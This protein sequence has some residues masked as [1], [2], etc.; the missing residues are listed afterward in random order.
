MSLIED[1]EYSCL[2]NMGEVIIKPNDEAPMWWDLYV[3]G[4]LL[5]AAQFDSPER[6]ALSA[7]KRDFGHQDLNSKYI[8][9]RVSSDLGRWRKTVL[10][11]KKR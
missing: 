5:C 7:S 11:Y 4:R 8:G 1:C 10:Y 2:S 6:A 9:L 3:D